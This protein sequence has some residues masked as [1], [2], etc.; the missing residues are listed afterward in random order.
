MS[1]RM[2]FAMLAAL[3]MVALTATTGTAAAGKAQPCQGAYS[4]PSKTKMRTAVA[5]TLCVINQTRHA[6]GLRLFQMNGILRAIAAGQSHDMLVGGYFGDE[7]LSGQTPMQ[8]IEASAFGRGSTR[9]SVGQNIAWGDGGQST[10][11]AIVAA[12]LS[13][14]PHREIL[15]APSFQDVGVGISLGAPRRTS[16]KAGAI[17][18]LVLAARRG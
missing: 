6:H 11:A 7:S 1:L 14:G 4:R 17:Y 15:L 18:T 13:S 3:A 12:W 16:R 8:R 10:P 5:A 9:L 2:R